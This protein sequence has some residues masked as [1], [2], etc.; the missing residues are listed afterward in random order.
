MIS[1]AVR[2]IRV[3]VVRVGVEAG[4]FSTTT[5]L[6]NA[7]HVLWIAPAGKRCVAQLVNGDSFQVD[8][9]AAELAKRLATE[10]L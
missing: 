9:P 6:V 4:E 10:G 2:F 3:D 8:E 5:R 1:R 7:D